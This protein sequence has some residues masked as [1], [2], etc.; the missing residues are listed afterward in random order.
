MFITIKNTEKNNLKTEKK[1]CPT[2]YYGCVFLPPDN[3]I[4]NMLI[5]GLTSN[6]IR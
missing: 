6:L 2:K 1:L 5:K 3:H 4:T